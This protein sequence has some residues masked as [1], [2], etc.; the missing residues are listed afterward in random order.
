MVQWKM[1]AKVIEK[2]AVHMAGLKGSTPYITGKNIFMELM[3]ANVSVSDIY[4]RSISDGLTGRD[5]ERSI[6]AFEERDF[7]AEWLK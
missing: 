6:K 3:K 7:A 4:A 2:G 5:I 1:T